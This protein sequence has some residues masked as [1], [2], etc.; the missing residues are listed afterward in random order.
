MAGEVRNRRENMRTASVGASDVSPA[1]YSLRHWA[2]ERNGIAAE[3]AH[4]LFPRKSA[5]DHPKFA[6]RRARDHRCATTRMHP[7]QDESFLKKANKYRRF[8]VDERQPF[9]ASVREP[10]KPTWLCPNLLS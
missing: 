1:R 2:L 10:G 9:L 5:P 4:G 7:R 3:F 6:P 8:N